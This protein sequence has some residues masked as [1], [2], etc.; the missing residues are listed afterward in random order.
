MGLPICANLVRAGCG[1]IAWDQ[2]AGR[3][4]AVIACG[5]QWAAT[6]DQAAAE[7]EVLI[8]VLPGTQELQD[9]ML[10]TR[11]VLAALPVAATWIDMTSSSPDEGQALAEAARARGIGMLEA[12][13]CGG[14][15]AA[16]AGTLRLLIGGDAALLERHRV[17]LEVLGDPGRITHVGGPGAGYTAKL[18]VNL[19]W[20]GQA[21]ATAEALLVGSRCGIDLGTLR[22]VLADSAAASGFIARDL[23]ALLSGDYLA[24]FGLDRCWEELAA[25]T[26][27]ARE[28]GVPCEL[29][30]LV[31][32]IYRR[33]LARYGPADGEL[34]PIAMLEDEAGIRLRAEPQ[35]APE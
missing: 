13:M 34:L 27:L 3:E 17:L 6:A 23:D 16:Q 24:C 8:T 4:K 18:L 25:V 28:H 30:A 32:L 11:G 2:Q 14:V 21:I 31:E 5:A 9:L 12:P 26:A 33:A 35:V 15:P 19:L 10:G 1:V 22:R 20:F 7:T 29:S